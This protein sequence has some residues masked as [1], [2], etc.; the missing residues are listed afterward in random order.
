MPASARLQSVDALRGLAILAVLACHLFQGHAPHGSWPVSVLGHQVFLASPLSNSFQAVALFFVLSGFVLYLPYAQGR[1]SMTS[2]AEVRA[3][4][5]RRCRRLVPLYLVVATMGLVW[6]SG[7]PNPMEFLKHVAHY[8]TVS[9]VLT[10]A[11]YPAGHFALWSIQVELQ[12]CLLFPALVWVM[13]RWGVGRSLFL[14]VSLSF[15][16]RWVGASLAGP[17]SLQSESVALFRDTIFARMDDFAWGMLLAHLYALRPHAPQAMRTLVVGGGVIL[18]SFQLRDHLFLTTP[19][20]LGLAALNPL[21]AL[22]CLLVTRGCLGLEIR[23]HLPV[24]TTWLADLGVIS[25]SVY[26]WHSLI[27]TSLQTN[28]RSSTDVILYLACL[29]GASLL[30][31]RLLETGRLLTLARRLASPPRGM[32]IIH[33]RAPA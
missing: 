24:G 32:W 20:A 13:R 28:S 4:L 17:A 2:W 12:F 9:H 15:I 22:G 29:T 19:S 21:T 14:I 6:F 25:Y 11:F 10:S 23:R 16:V 7:Q 1:R 33:E 18:L 31:Y 3:F 5:W 27:Q 30:S 26:S 8:L